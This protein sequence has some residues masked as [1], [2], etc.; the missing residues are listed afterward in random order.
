MNARQYTDMKSR[1]DFISII[2]FTNIKLNKYHDL[3]D[4]NSSNV[5]IESR[6]SK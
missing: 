2:L 1:I 3:S 6:E 4:D 5:N